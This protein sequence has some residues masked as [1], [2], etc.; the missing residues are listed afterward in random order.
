MPRQGHST[1]SFRKRRMLEVQPQSHTWNGYL[2]AYLQV[3]KVVIKRTPACS[4]HY[5]TLWTG[6]NTDHRNSAPE[7]D[8]RGFEETVCM[9]SEEM[10]RYAMQSEWR[11][12][13]S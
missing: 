3:T 13:H 2:V 9:N 1:C 5:I 10:G 4:H 8:Q 11:M 7:L 12:Q 6:F